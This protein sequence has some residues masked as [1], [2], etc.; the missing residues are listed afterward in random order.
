VRDDDVDDD[1]DFINNPIDLWEHPTGL[2]MALLVPLA[3][4]QSDQSQASFLRPVTGQFIP[5][6]HKPVYSDQLQASLF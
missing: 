1:D 3:T 5:T 4:G 6:N 2:R